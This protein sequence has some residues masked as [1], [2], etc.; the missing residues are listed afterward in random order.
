VWSPRFEIRQKS[1]NLVFVYCIL[2]GGLTTVLPYFTSYASE[3]SAI[4]TS[5]NGVIIIVL[6]YAVCR[7]KA[8]AA[9]ALVALALLDIGSRAYQGWDGYL[10]P[11]ILLLAAL[12]ATGPLKPRQAPKHQ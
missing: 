11:G 7:G 4:G 3:S 9:W 1:V 2:W 10:M 6:G 8:K 5:L 12:S